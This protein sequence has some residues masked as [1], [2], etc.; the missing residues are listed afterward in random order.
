ML[1]WNK[2][3]RTVTFI[4]TTGTY[5]LNNYHLKRKNV[6]K[7]IKN[8]QKLFILRSDLIPVVRSGTKASNYRPAK[9]KTVSSRAV[10]N[11]IRSGITLALKINEKHCDTFSPT[12]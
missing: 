5:N 2:T 4:Y 11:Y 6:V 9:N 1:V 7:T 3:I 12:S 8:S 10:A